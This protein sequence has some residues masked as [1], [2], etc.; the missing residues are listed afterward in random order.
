MLIIRRP[1]RLLR[2]AAAFSAMTMLILTPGARAQ[3]IN[4]DTAQRAPGQMEQHMP[5][6]SFSYVIYISVPPNTLWAAFFDPEIQKRC[7]P[8]YHLESDWRRGSNWRMVSPEGQTA[9]EGEVVEIEQPHRLVLTWRND[10]RPERIAEGYSRVVIEFEPVAQATK[11]VVTH[12]LD[13]PR[14][15]LIAAASESWPH[16]LSNLKSLIETGHIAAPYE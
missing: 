3:P 1:L 6:S 5:A 10:V 14:S 8:G 16:I 9:N 11:V 15:N 4:A 13:R 12:S 2:T 7:W